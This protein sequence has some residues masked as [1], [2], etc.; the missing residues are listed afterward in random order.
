MTSTARSRWRSMRQ[1]AV[2]HAIRCMNQ[3]YAM[4]PY[5]R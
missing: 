2:I 5:A 4:N 3:G 1:A